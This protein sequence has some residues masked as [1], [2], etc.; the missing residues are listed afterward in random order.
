MEVFIRGSLHQLL[1]TNWN[2]PRLRWQHHSWKIN[3]AS[4][5]CLFLQIIRIFKIET[6][7]AS[8]AVA[9]RKVRFWTKSSCIHFEMKTLE[10][11]VG[12]HELYSHFRTGRNLATLSLTLPVLMWPPP[13]SVMMSS[14]LSSPARR[15]GSIVAFLLVVLRNNGRQ[16]SVLRWVYFLTLP[17]R[18]WTLKIRMKIPWTNWKARRLCLAVFVKATIGPRAVRTRTPWA[19]CRRSWPNSSAS[20]PQTRTSPLAPVP[21]APRA[22]CQD[23]D[24]LAV[25]YVLTDVACSC[26]F[27]LQRSQSRRSPRRARPGSTCPRAWGTEARGEGSPCSPTGGVDVSGSAFFFTWFIGRLLWIGTNCPCLPA[28]A[29]DNATIRVTNLSEDTRETD[30]QELFRPFGSISRIYLAKDKNTGQ[31]KVSAPLQ[32]THGNTSRNEF[33]TCRHLVTSWPC[34][35]ES[36]QPSKDQPLCFLQGFAFISF[37]RRED[38]ARAITGVSGFG[39]DH[40]ILNVEWAK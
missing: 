28:T 29:D 36:E 14:W 9:R 19:R 30:L 2:R 39:Y 7:K 37:H 25:S 20:P 12:L 10:G 18:T 23:F 6:R 1:S 5:A 26:S 35:H 4:S 11:N 32:N 15:W 16:Q 24:W 8:K 40:L 33:I 21:A 17:R 38:A 3:Y 22:H 27:S 31:S 13:Q 34:L